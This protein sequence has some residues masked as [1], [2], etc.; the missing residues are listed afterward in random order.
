MWVTKM[1][2]YVGTKKLKILGVVKNDERR[3]VDAKTP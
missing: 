1:T 2:T 3:D